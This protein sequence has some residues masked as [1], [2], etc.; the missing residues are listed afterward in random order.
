MSG[1]GCISVAA[2]RDFDG[3]GCYYSGLQSV[4]AVV[5]VRWHCNVA[6]GFVRGLPAEPLDTSRRNKVQK[7]QGEGKETQAEPVAKRR[8]KK[9]TSRNRDGSGKSAAGKRGELK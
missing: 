9:I 3:E 4:V 5:R 7:E 6:G 8:E 2:R 1:K